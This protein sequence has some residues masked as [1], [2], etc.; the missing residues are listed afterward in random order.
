MGIFFVDSRN[1]DDANDGTTLRS[2]VKTLARAR[3]IMDSG[4]FGYGDRM[5]FS[6]EFYGPVPVMPIRR[7]LGLE[8]MEMGAFNDVA[9]FI[10]HKII[11]RGWQAY[12]GP[13]ND[14]VNV[15]V[16]DIAPGAVT[17]DG[18]PTHE[19]YTEGDGRNIGHLYIDGVFHGDNKLTLSQLTEQWQFYTD[20]PSDVTQRLFVYSEERPDLLADYIG[21]ATNSTGIITR[22]GSLH[23]DFELF[24]FGA[25]GA[26]FRT[27][28]R[29]IR[30]IILRNGHIHGYG[31]A[32]QDAGTG[33]R[34]GNGIEVWIGA[35]HSQV[36]GVVVEDG[37]DAGYTL[38]GDIIPGDDWYG[39]ND[40][41]VVDSTF[42]RN[43]QSVEFWARQYAATGGF[44]SIDIHHNLFK[45]AGMSWG[46]KVRSDGGKGA[47][48][49]TYRMTMPTDIAIHDNTFDGFADYYRYHQANE[50]GGTNI[51]DGLRAYRNN[52]IG[53]REQLIQYGD[54]RTFAQF[55]AWSAD[56][57]TEE[58]STWTMD[59]EPG[60]RIDQVAS[61]ALSVASR[62]ASVAVKLASPAVQRS[63]PSKGSTILRPGRWYTHERPSS[64]SSVTFSTQ[65]L[66][67]G[68]F[69]EAGRKSA[70]LQSLGALSVS[71][72]EAN[73]RIR[74][75]AY[76]VFATGQAVRRANLG[77]FSGT[78]PDEN[79]FDAL[80]SE[81]KIGDFDIWLCLVIQN[82]NQGV[83]LTTPPVLRAME[84]L[85]NPA[86]SS[87]NV[88]ASLGTG[89]TGYSY[90]VGDGELPEVIPALTPLS[91]TPLM[92]WRTVS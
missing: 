63:A 75:G 92:A 33:N 14:L 49:L 62:A 43:N 86:I 12:T 27:P 38:Q 26:R 90:N 48:I 13:Q 6:G 54:P 31:G 73:A 87:A 24:G 70:Y 25:H 30:D 41:E 9:R 52:I 34:F 42:R 11:R 56:R 65:G 61:V 64:A 88:T 36:S 28:Q 44:S 45:D 2:P 23:E 50:F 59:G 69:I 80:S 81:L 71:A 22:A 57:H 66:A 85:T 17:S 74:V 83:A 4:R 51:P 68:P 55:D 10:G 67:A 5:E 20:K 89:Y 47:H 77:Q 76:E 21:A 32:R 35:D 3:S 39:W 19:G 7:R 46:A 18:Q 16:V 37:Y 15:W 29:R 8:Y 79:I 72:G 84:A 60:E 58:L 78:R 82:I 1:G 53:G 91:R 40:H